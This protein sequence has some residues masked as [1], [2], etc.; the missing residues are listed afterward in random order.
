[1]SFDPARFTGIVDC[2][3]VEANG[4][5]LNLEFRLGGDGGGYYVLHAEQNGRAVTFFLGAAEWRALEKI[6]REGR[7]IFDALQ[8]GGRCDELTPCPPG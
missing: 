1:M 3:F 7:A 6:M 8:R 4:G 2:G 5:G